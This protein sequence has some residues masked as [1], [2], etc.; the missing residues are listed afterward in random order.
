MAK[1]SY[2][3]FVG[4]WL[5]LLLLKYEFEKLPEGIVACYFMLL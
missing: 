2:I 1:R 3:S 4:G 5:L